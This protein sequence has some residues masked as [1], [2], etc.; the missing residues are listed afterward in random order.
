MAPSLSPAPAPAPGEVR[1][2]LL[3]ADK[4]H[5]SREMRRFPQWMPGNIFGRT[6]AFC[7]GVPELPRKPGTTHGALQ[8]PPHRTQRAGF[9]H[10]A[11]HGTGYG[12]QAPF[13]NN[14]R[15]GHRRSI[16]TGNLG[17]E[18]KSAG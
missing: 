7:R 9:P 18:S 12:A 3:A 15:L 16:G 17:I 6:A 5:E 11:H 13:D 1:F 10:C 2:R 14:M 4:F 8:L